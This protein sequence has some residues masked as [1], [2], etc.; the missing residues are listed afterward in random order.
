MHLNFSSCHRRQSAQVT[1]RARST[2]IPGTTPTTS[3]TGRMTSVHK[4]APTLPCNDH[5]RGRSPTSTTTP[6]RII[7]TTTRTP[8]TSAISEV[9]HPARRHPIGRIRYK[10]RPSRDQR[11]TADASETTAS[12]PTQKAEWRP[13]RR[14]SHSTH[15]LSPAT[16]ANLPASNPRQSYSPWLRRA[17]TVETD[18][19]G[20]GLR[21]W[22]CSTTARGPLCPSPWLPPPRPLF[23]TCTHGPR[24]V[25]PSSPVVSQ[26]GVRDTNSTYS[27]CPSSPARAAHSLRPR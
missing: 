23:T 14:A 27:K 20:L 11:D 17:T 16:P 1:C 7:T 12:L 15:H 8:T 19:V 24:M 21:M 10:T 22:L 4:H 5:T 18:A 3:P 25:L 2:F 26:A 9:G 6:L 13:R